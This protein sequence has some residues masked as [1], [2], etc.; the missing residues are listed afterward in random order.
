MDRPGTSNS[1]CCASKSSLIHIPSTSAVGTK[2]RRGSNVVSVLLRCQT[3]FPLMGPQYP[4]MYAG[5]KLE[6][7]DVALV[8]PDRNSAESLEAQPSKDGQILNSVI[9]TAIGPGTHSQTCRIRMTSTYVYVY[10]Y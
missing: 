8:I 4:D 2:L 3:C 1:L 6:P 10:I 9:C 7:L 5:T